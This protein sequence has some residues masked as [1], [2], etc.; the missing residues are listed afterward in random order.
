MTVDPTLAPAPGTTSLSY[1]GGL[2]DGTTPG[3]QEIA[4]GVPGVWYRSTC[5]VVGLGSVFVPGAPGAP[6]AAPAA[7]PPPSPA[8]LAQIAYGEIQLGA[9]G[10]QLSPSSQI[11]PAIYQIVNAPT[12]AWVPSANWK[13][14][15]ATASA[16][17]V[18]V[19]ATAIPSSITVTYG[20]GGAT[21][22][23]TCGGPGT[24]YSDQLAEREDP[25]APLSAAS[26][27]CGWTYEH[28]S[29]GA[30]GGKEPV[31]G[32]VTYHVTWTVTGAPG[33]GD[34]GPLNSPATTYNVP[35]AEIQVVNT[36]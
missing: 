31:A 7:P 24:P 12:W 15:S 33:G 23:A 5:A 17:P 9:P 22:T 27:D 35:V 19:T 8:Q 13:P 34:L 26:P 20:D 28:T 25:G 29:A 36:N 30:P 21:R 10:L 1:P 2:G 11:N 14:L 6:G 4:A 16:G 32:V 3:V 18:V